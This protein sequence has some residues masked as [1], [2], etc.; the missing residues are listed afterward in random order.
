MMMAG[1]CCGA[2]PAC[3]GLPSTISA[4]WTGTYESCSDQ[5]SGEDCSA[6]GTNITVSKTF[7]LTKSCDGASTRYTGI[8]CGIGTFSVCEVGVCDVG[9]VCQNYTINAAVCITCGESPLCWYM[10][11]SAS[12]YPISPLGS[13]SACDCADLSVASGSCELVNGGLCSPNNF[14]W[15]VNCGST[16]YEEGSKCGAT[17]PLGTYTLT[18]GTLVV[19]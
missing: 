8:A 13:C 2:C 6:G 10:N 16:A 5:C 4:T 9:L 19:A 3:A 18:F 17:S 7:T 11:A 15:T 12:A 14:S 1:C